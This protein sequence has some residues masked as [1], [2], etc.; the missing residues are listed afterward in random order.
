MK[1]RSS[2]FPVVISG[3]SGVGKTTLEKRVVSSDPLL[4]A[5][6][7]ATTRAPREG[8]ATG[9]DYFFVKRDVFEEMKSRELVEWAEVH[10]EFY[11]TP[12]RFIEH[13]LE[14]GHDVILN[15]DFQGGIGVKKAF[16]GAVLIF[17]LPPSFEDLRLRILKRGSDE[18]PDIET[19]L[20]NAREE[21]KASVNYDYLVVNDDLGRAVDEILAIIAAER[22]RRERHAAGFFEDLDQSNSS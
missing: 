22:C 7:S 5:S 4:R 8:E 17:I 1:R 20:T 10:G 21:I 6:I 11:G 3:P 9:K 15:I 13:E 19:R 14:Q 2:A 16:P 12:R 18:P